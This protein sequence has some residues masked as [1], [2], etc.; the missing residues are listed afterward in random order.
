MNKLSNKTFLVDF[1]IDEEIENE[2]K[3]ND[4]EYIKTLKNENLYEEISGHPDISACNLGDVTVVDPDTYNLLYEQIK[5]FNIIKGETILRSKYPYDIAYNFIVT[6]K[7]I[8]GKL[9]YMD[10]VVRKLAEKKGLEFIN[11]KQGYARCS[12]ISLPKDRFITSDSN[13]YETL[14]S[15]N[16]K[17]YLIECQDIYLSERYNGFLGGSCLIYDDEIMFFGNIDS[18]GNGDILKKILK[19]NHIKYYDIN[20]LKLKDYGSMIKL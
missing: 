4:I 14:I 5:D 2:L 19:E 3:K 13:I 10:K 20:N 9:N 12:T 8:I 1:R 15:K 11:V 6:E 16:L 18:I 7:Y 17:C